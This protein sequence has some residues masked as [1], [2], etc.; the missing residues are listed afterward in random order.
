MEDDLTG[1]DEQRGYRLV[2]ECQH[3]VAGNLRKNLVKFAIGKPDEGQRIGRAAVLD[4]DDLCLHGGDDCRQFVQSGLID[5]A[6]RAFGDRRLED[7]RGF[8]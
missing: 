3:P 1:R 8:P 5:M 6:R 7:H 4:L 2:R